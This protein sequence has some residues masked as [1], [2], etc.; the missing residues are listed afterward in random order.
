MTD[1]KLIVLTW[2]ASA[3]I[4]LGF[5]GGVVLAA[6]WLMPWLASVVG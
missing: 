5:W 2:T 4:A 1:T 3:A 6:C